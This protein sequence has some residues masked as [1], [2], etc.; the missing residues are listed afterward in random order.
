MVLVRLALRVAPT[1]LLAW[2]DRR[3]A[4]L[5]ERIATLAWREGSRRRKH[6]RTAHDQFIPF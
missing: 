4:P 1:R 5:G 2:L 3:R 6:G